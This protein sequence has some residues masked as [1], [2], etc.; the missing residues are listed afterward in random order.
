MS[1]VNS[2]LA[3]VRA[4]N[5]KSAK[6]VKNVKNKSVKVAKP[7][8]LEKYRKAD[9]SADRA[10]KESKINDT[11]EVI[12][13]SRKARSGLEVENIIEHLREREKIRKNPAKRFTTGVK[14]IDEIFTSMGKSGLKCGIYL[15][16]GDPGSG[17]S[18]WALQIMANMRKQGH[19]GAYLAYEGKDNIYECCRRIGLPEIISIVDQE[20][21]WEP[22]SEK[23]SELLI[24]VHKANDTGKPAVFTVDSVKN[25]NA[26][27]G[28]TNGRRKAIKDLLKTVEKTNSIVFLIGHVSKETR[29]KKVKRIQGPSELEELCDVRI[30]FVDVTPKESK[31]MGFRHIMLDT[32][33]KNRHGRPGE[34]YGYMLQETGFTFPDKLLDTPHDGVDTERSEE[35]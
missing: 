28:T 16:V 31:N 20:D 12:E 34:F 14:S 4:S 24:K 3:K 33:T 10:V 30:D 8:I 5:T 9:K 26:A 11:S 23:L 35:L 15:L 17:K 29:G 1:S 19:L 7:S 2:L 18:S 6:V 22:T 32:S 25:L 13:K 27:D 21:G